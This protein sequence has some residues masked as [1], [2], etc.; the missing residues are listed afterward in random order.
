VGAVLVSWGLEICLLAGGVRHAFMDDAGGRCVRVPPPPV[1]ASRRARPGSGNEKA[2][3]ARRKSSFFNLWP[4]CA[5]AAAVRLIRGR[6]RVSSGGG[7]SHQNKC[8]RPKQGPAGQIGQS[9]LWPEL[10]VSVALSPPP[11][12]VGANDFPGSAPGQTDGASGLEW[13]DPT[14]S[15]S[16]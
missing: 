6:R 12:V 10:S 8:A 4:Q 2:A 3:A 16:I 13:A 9:A 5:R 1:R 14:S 15:L 11:L 7:P